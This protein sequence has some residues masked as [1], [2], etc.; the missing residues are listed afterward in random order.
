MPVPYAPHSEE[1]NDPANADPTAPVAPAGTCAAEAPGKAVSRHDRVLAG[2]REA[3]HR[4]LAGSPCMALNSPC[5]MVLAEELICTSDGDLRPDLA[6]F[7]EKAV[8]NADHA[9]GAPALVVEVQITS[10]M[11]RDTT[12]RLGLYEQ[13]GIPEYWIVDINGLLVHAHALNEEGQMELYQ[14]AASG[15]VLKSKTMPF[16]TIPAWEGW[17]DDLP[18]SRV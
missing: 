4:A 6:V 17:L 2:I 13:L 14:S 11:L 10:T 12:S 5:C 15:E 1:G 3:L 16:L 8:F 18:P 9:D 7:C